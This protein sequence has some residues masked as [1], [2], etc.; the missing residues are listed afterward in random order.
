LESEAKGK[1]EALRIRKKLEQDINELEVAL[2]VSNRGKAEVEKNVKRYI[3]QI[4]ELQRK[5]EEEQRLRDEARE[6][7]VLTERR[8]KIHHHQTIPQLNDLQQ[9]ILTDMACISPSTFLFW[10]WAELS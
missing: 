10:V 7:Y 9:H 6:S 8:C 5:I 4:Q 2:D 3:S 1:S